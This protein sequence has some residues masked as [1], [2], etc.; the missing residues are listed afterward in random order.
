MQWSDGLARAFE[1]VI[2]F[3]SSSETL[4]DEDLGETVDLVQDS[5]IFQSIDWVSI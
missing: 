3:L 4:L 5:G 2:Q 1:V